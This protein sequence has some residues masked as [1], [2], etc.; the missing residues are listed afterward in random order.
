[1]PSGAVDSFAAKAVEDTFGL[2]TVPDGSYC[3]TRPRRMAADIVGRQLRMAKHTQC[4][5]QGLM[6]VAQGAMDFKEAPGTFV[7]KRNAKR[8]LSA[9]E[10]QTGEMAL[11]FFELQPTPPKNIASTVPLAAVDAQIAQ[12]LPL[13]HSGVASGPSRLRLRISL[14]TKAASGKKDWVWCV[15]YVG[16]D[17]VVFKQYLAGDVLLT[18]P[19]LRVVRGQIRADI[20]I[21]K[22]FR[23]PKLSKDATWCR[24]MGFDWGVGRLLTGTVVTAYKDGTLTT[25][26]IG[27]HFNAARWHKEDHIRRLQAER[28]RTKAVRAEILAAGC[29]DLVKRAQHLTRAAKYRLDAESTDKARVNANKE[30]CRLAAVWAVNLALAAGA[31]VLAIENLD[32]MEPKYGKRLRVNLSTRVRGMLRGALKTA[33]RNVG[34]VFVEVDPANTS[35]ICGRC[36][37]AVKHV[38]ASNNHSGGWHWSYCKH[39]KQGWDRDHNAAL[40]IAVR[41]IRSPQ[42][43]KQVRQEGHVTGASTEDLGG[44][45]LERAEPR[46]APPKRRTSSVH[47]PQAAAIQKGSGSNK[48]QKKGSKTK[49]RRAGRGCTPPRPGAR[50][51]GV[52]V[53]HRSAGPGN[54]QT[55]LNNT[56][57]EQSGE[58]SSS[59]VREVV[60]TRKIRVRT[61]DGMRYAHR[62]SIRAT[63]IRIP[64]WERLPAPDAVLSGK[65]KKT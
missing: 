4:V 20:T 26:G 54:T 15:L 25:D 16:V 60:S 1:M 17:P 59:T 49:R 3:T 19:T 39:C 62:H 61:L 24:V 12:W 32:S 5:T 42:S 35:V 45:T 58:D 30:L 22:P 56:A 18:R 43:G 29:T 63:P 41:A 65:S 48:D 31:T 6:L 44:V 36:G 33:C 13:D 47:N 27:V 9:Y 23:K 34:I 53:V 7:E 38:K 8:Y 51:S 21:D 28:L 52:L 10:R 64:H 11:N 40:N 57:R 14:P 50:A 55:R 37:N 2:A 46:V